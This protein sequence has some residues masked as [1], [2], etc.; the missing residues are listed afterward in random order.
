M[1][2][3]VTVIA[4]GVT[5]AYPDDGQRG[6]ATPDCGYRGIVP[7]YQLGTGSYATPEYSS[8]GLLSNICV[9]QKSYVTTR[10][11]LRVFKYFVRPRMWRRVKNNTFYYTTVCVAALCY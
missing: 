6:A 1:T 9:I 11:T 5:Y 4:R 2:T 8:L 7:V 3:G 10:R